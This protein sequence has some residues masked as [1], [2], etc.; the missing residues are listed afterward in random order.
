MVISGNIVDVVNGKIFGGDIEIVNKNI[1]AVRPNNTKY[2]TYILPGF[3]DAHIHI[4]SSMLIPTEFA[5]LAVMHG[6]VA[7]VSDPHEIANVLGIKGVEFMI[8]NAKETRFKFYF[9]APSCVPATTFETT[10]AALNSDAIKALL[11]KKEIKFLSEMMNVQSILNQDKEALEKIKAA[12]ELVKPID[13]HVPGLV[14]GS[15]DIYIAAG[16]STDHEVFTYEEGKEKLKKGMKLLIREGSA[17]K[18]FDTLIP[19]IEAHSQNIMFC[20]DDRHPNDLLKEHINGFVKRAVSQGYDVMKVLASACVNP[21]RHYN[22][23]VGL[24]QVGDRADFIMVNDIEKFEVL[25]TWIDGKKV[26]KDGQTLLRHKKIK[27]VNKFLCSKKVVDDFNV[28]AHGGKVRVIGAIDGELKTKEIDVEPK[29]IKGNIVS[30]ICRDI[31]KI[32]VINRYVNNKPPFVGFVKNFGLKKG[33]IA[34]SIA[35]DS[36]N[37]IV[38]G[39][40]DEE[41]CKAVN[42]VIKYKGGICAAYDDKKIVMPLEVAGL[43][44]SNDGFKIAEK[45]EMLDKTVKD[46][47]GSKLSSPFM[48]LSFMALLVIPE[49]KISD[50][51]LFDSRHFH[52]VHRFIEDDK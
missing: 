29:V 17:S 51:G 21:V 42:L 30:D 26:Y 40:S 48:T 41:I 32:A 5:R 27:P 44:S 52:I 37:I 1:I 33:A 39:C 4:E 6:T 12:R 10:G 24:L 36:H 22:L 3:I 11:Q 34:S 35:H 15:L 28:K 23:D 49:L 47:L 13:G 16:M 50:K 38:V 20:S 43:M 7:T 18:N 31:L 8:D 46:E 25:E 2:R 19:L 9:G 45:Y 14:G